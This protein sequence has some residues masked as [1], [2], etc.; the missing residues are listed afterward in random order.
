MK[1]ERLK[2]WH[3]RYYPEVDFGFKYKFLIQKF[4]IR[5][6]NKILIWRGGWVW[7]SGTKGIIQKLTLHLKDSRQR[8][9][10]I[11]LE[12]E[13][14]KI[15]FKIHRESFWEEKSGNVTRNHLE[16]STLTLSCKLC[17]FPFLS[18]N[19]RLDHIL[20][21]FDNVATTP[22]GWKW[23]FVHLEVL[24]TRLLRKTF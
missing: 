2:I 11:G 20:H 3:K 5:F 7:K 6:Y 21:S 10:R 14:G 24:Q 12:M 17:S 15:D 13:K 19:A 23:N 9:R 1:R 16:K 18:G 22:K 4:R 8:R